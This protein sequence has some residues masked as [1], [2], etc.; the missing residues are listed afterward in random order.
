MVE[1][2][3][4]GSNILIIWIEIT[5]YNIFTYPYEWKDRRHKMGETRLK[6]KKEKQE[7]SKKEGKRKGGRRKSGGRSNILLARIPSITAFWLLGVL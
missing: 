5:F 3:S 4:S 1:I 7:E 2:V 6:K